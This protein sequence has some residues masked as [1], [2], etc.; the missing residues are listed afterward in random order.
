MF[1]DEAVLSRSEKVKT[2]ETSIE[3]S[4]QELVQQMEAGKSE[5]LVQYLE[6]CAQFHEYSFRN[7]LLALWQRPGLTRLAGLRQWNKLG[8]RV[9]A[10]EKGIAILAPMTVKRSRDEEDLEEEPNVITLFKV[11]Y[12]FDVSQTEGD[13]LPD[14]VHATGDV[15]VLYPRLVEAVQ[16]AGIKLEVL[17]DVPGS[18]GALGASYGGRIVLRVDLAPADAFRTLVHEYAHELL[19]WRAAKEDKTI[20]ETEADA[21]AFIVCRHFSIECD[22]ADYLQ[23][24]DSTTHVLLDRLET[25]RRTA[26]RIIV[27]LERDEDA[28]GGQADDTPAAA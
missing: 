28:E 4:S 16:E 26:A 11:V 20:C 8:R 15:S 19:H 3:E 23:L 18:F 7:I 17:E 24:H 27:A 9:K 6:Y 22:T 14:L 12:V 13:P 10:G 2:L 1:F 25:I 5:T 21:T